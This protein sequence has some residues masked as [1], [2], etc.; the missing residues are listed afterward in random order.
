VD[1]FSFLGNLDLTSIMVTV[2]VVFL[3][4]K[5]GPIVQALAPFI[6]SLFGGSKAPTPAPSPN[7]SPAP[8]P[9]LPD[10]PL[11]LPRLKLLR[12]LIE[13]ILERAERTQNS[14][15]AQAEALDALAAALGG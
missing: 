10:V 14:Q 8:L 1:P 12:D 9:I 3:G 15:K 4:P 7:P 6:L 11:D 13:S 5:V 2:A